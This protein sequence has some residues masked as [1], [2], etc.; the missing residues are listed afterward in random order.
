MK[1]KIFDFADKIASIDQ[2]KSVI[3]DIF[4]DDEVIFQAIKKCYESMPNR[5]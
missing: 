2:L 4:F 1:D 5:I 3:E